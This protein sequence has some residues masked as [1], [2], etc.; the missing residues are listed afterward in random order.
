M[1]DRDDDLRLP[2]AATL[3]E[4]TVPEPTDDLAD[5]IAD[6]W[7]EER[8]HRAMPPSRPSHGLGGIF[9]GAVVGAAAAALVMLASRPSEPRPLEPAPVPASVVDPVAPAIAAPEVRPAPSSRVALRLRVEPGSA[10]VRVDGRIVAAEDL[11]ETRYLHVTTPGHHAVQIHKEGY[12]DETLELDVSEE[13]LAVAVELEPEP[14]AIDPAAAP[15]EARPRSRRS[16]FDELFGRRKKKTSDGGSSSDLKNPFKSSTAAAAK[17][18]TLRIGTTSGAKP[19]QVYVDGKAIGSTPI[20]SYKVTPGHHV[21][22]WAWDDGK[23]ITER[24]EI[25]ANGTQT[26]KRG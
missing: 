5:R 6:A 21:I 1:D 20:A 15:D 26:Y 25:E 16:P 17:T 22:K 4:W 2:E 23:T 24:I 3:E 9:L 8:R 10:A 11:A 14:P 7:Q 13:G 12:V 18:A 19:A